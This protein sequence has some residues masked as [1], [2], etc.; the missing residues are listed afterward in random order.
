MPGQRKADSGELRANAERRKMDTILS[1]GNK[2]HVK[3]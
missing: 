1:K 3:E 2:P